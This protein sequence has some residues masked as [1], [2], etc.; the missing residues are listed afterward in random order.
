MTCFFGDGAIRQGAFHESLNMAKVM[1][2][3][4][5]Y[6][7]ENNQYGMGTDFRRVSS[8]E[9]FSLMGWS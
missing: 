1:R 8:M 3:P 4:V 7:C 5:I 6:I 2:L 9:D